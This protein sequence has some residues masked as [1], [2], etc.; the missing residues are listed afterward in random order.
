MICM[1]HSAHSTGYN[2][3]WKLQTLGGGEHLLNMTAHESNMTR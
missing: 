1:G 2:I 3:L